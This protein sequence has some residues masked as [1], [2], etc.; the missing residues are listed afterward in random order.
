METASGSLPMQVRLDVINCDA[1]LKNFLEQIEQELPFGAVPV[2][3]E[4]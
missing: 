1:F 3:F 2:L 4:G